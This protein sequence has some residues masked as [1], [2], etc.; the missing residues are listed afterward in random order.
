MPTSLPDGACGSRFPAD[1]D[2]P[3]SA[4][5][6]SL[7]ENLDSGESEGWPFFT[8]DLAS[9]GCRQPPSPP[10]ATR[11]GTAE[12]PHRSGETACPGPG[13]TPL[14]HPPPSPQAHT[15]TGP[16]PRLASSREPAG[17]GFKHQSKQ[18]S[19]ISRHTGR[20]Q[21]KLVR[22]A[23]GEAAHRHR[24]GGW[25][26]NPRPRDYEISQGAFRDCCTTR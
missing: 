8:S 26:S 22:Q 12:A 25:G 9:R 18:L 4:D 17:R 11:K 23:S 2:V 15:G 20:P 3:L 13:C 19:S 16:P 21:P 6:Q 1:L 14:P 10:P 24:W 7:E 5:L